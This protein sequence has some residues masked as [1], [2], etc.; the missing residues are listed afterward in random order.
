M[1]TAAPVSVDPSP[2]R[3]LRLS[4]SPLDW[5]LNSTVSGA[6]PWV[7]LAVKSATGAA[8]EAMVVLTSL[9]KALQFVRA[10]S[11]ARTAKW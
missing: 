5:S 2:K 6:S 9:E 4:M 7:T 11:Q 1:T 8:G 10:A 3:H